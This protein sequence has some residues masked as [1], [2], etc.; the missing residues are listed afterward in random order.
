[1]VKSTFRTITVIEATSVI[2]STIIGVG[3]LA[4]P[5]IAAEA[6]NT[7]APMV[8]TIGIVIAFI[9][10]WLIT[11]LGMRFPN[12]SIVEYSEVILGKW[13]ARALSLLII[14]F[15]ACLTS[16]AAREFSKVVVT[17]VLPRTPVE[18]NTIVMLLL[19]ALA[20]RA[21]M[22][23]FG[24]AHI[25][26]M[27]FLMAPA[28]FIVMFS[29]KNAV[30]TNIEPIVG[31]SPD[32]MA[33]LSGAVTVSA[34]FQG[35]FIMSFVI[36]AMRTPQKAMKACVWGI[37]IAGGLYLMT[38]I[39]AV[40]VFGSEETKQLLWPTLE[41]AK[42]TSLPGEV[43]ERLDAAFLAVWVSAVFTT[44]YSTYTLTI[45]GIRDL[46]RLS[47]HRMLTFFS[48]P[49]VFLIAMLPPNII[50]LYRV[51]ELVGRFGLWLTIAYPL[52]LLV[53]ANIR[54]LRDDTHEAS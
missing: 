41:L 11:K 34:L 23:T 10:L 42:A 22:S 39:A 50:Q 31:N 16:L 49:Y 29:L 26:Y 51:I 44:L 1:M 6:G 24:Y 45:R 30:L 3:V 7:G 43:L 20:S 40:S 32:W 28:V 52:L 14:V 48:L 47:D 21:N 54:K 33:I 13:F 53:V 4:L 19:A 37:V 35:S 17:S 9:G 8:T 2:V 5:R 27:P 18:I 36:P 38:V 15:F 25:F 12:Q 46:F